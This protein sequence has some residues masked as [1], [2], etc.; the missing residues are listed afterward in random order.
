MGTSKKLSN[1]PETLNSSLV[2]L[3]NTLSRRRILP[4]MHGD[5]IMRI[6][7][8]V[9]TMVF[10][11]R[12]HPLSFEQECQYLK[13]LGFG[14]ELWPNIRG[15]K[16]CRYQR[17]NWPRLQAATQGM[18]VS[19]RARTDKP[20]LEQW[21]EQI[22]CARM[23]GA[24]IVAELQSLDIAP[25]AELNGANFAAEVV[26]MA[27]D[28]DVKLCVET[29]PL[30]TMLSVGDRLKSLWYCLDTGYANIDS[31]HSF[32]QYVDALAP[33][34]AHLHLT[35]NYGQTD[36]H[37]PPGLQGGI[38]RENWDYLLHALETHDNDVVGAF[39]MCPCMPGVMIRQ[40]SEFVFDVLKW[41]NRP[42]K[43]PG[44]AEM[45]YHPT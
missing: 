25:N 10:W 41:P 21:A 37:E 43:Q 26:K 30:P 24:N 23:L 39:E 2:S 11:W 12:E 3:D 44:G 42:L 31:S 18:L 27:E 34:V 6:R 35:D 45:S 29:G 38:P 28:K 33:R 19:M 15:Q 8:V 32:E 20:T 16:E 17:R 1:W 7:Y 22:E 5:G 4:G 9:S 14:V 13:S 40:A 36:D